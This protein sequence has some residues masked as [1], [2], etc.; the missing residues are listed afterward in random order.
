MPLGAA[1]PLADGSGWVVAAGTGI[2]RTGGR[3]GLEWLA[4]PGDGSRRSLRMNGGACDPH[5][6]F[7]AVSMEARA[8]DGAGF[9]YRVDH[10]GTVSEVLDGLTAP[11]GPA[12]TSDGGLMYLADGALRTVHRHT[13]DPV[14]GGVGPAEVFARFAEDERRPAGMTVDDDGHLWVALRGGGRVVCLDV[15]SER[16]GTVQTP[17]TDTTSVAFG[18]G[19]MFVTTAS[20]RLQRPGPLDGAVLASVTTVTA[21]PARSFGPHSVVRE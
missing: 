16:L 9:L 19:L 7:R 10:D 21:P 1:A 15:D 8:E 13:V 5:G 3:G 12:F 6:R 2:A 14:T 17:A 20:H 18:C 4:R 11:G